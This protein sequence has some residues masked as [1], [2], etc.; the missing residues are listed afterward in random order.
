MSES[1]KEK[2][3][4]L[5]DLLAEPSV[6]EPASAVWAELSDEW[7]EFL[8]TLSD[9]AADAAKDLCKPAEGLGAVTGWTGR[10]WAK[11]V[12]AL[13]VWNRAKA[14]NPV[15][16]SWIGKL[17]GN[18]PETAEAGCKE[19]AALLYRK[20]LE[21]LKPDAASDRLSARQRVLLAVSL[22][23]LAKDVG[24]N[25]TDRAESRKSLHETPDAFVAE[26]IRRGLIEKGVA[27]GPA[28]VVSGWPAVLDDTNKFKDAFWAELK[29]LI[30][31]VGKAALP[32]FAAA[33]LV[34]ALTLGLLFLGVQNNNNRREF[35]KLQKGIKDIIP[36]AAKA[37]TAEDVIKAVAD[38]NA[39]VQ[40]DQAG[41]KDAARK[42]KSRIEELDTG[43]TSL[44]AEHAQLQAANNQNV[45]TIE[46][47]KKDLDAAT[48][49]AKKKG[50]DLA[51]L[52]D[53][54]KKA[55][56]EIA[57]QKSALADAAKT[58]A[59]RDAKIK[60][61]EGVLA[62]TKAD[63]DGTNAAL[64][65]KDRDLTAAKATIAK[66]D[67]EIK[68]LVGQLTNVNAALQASETKAASTAKELT[69]AKADLAKT[70]G[71]LA[72]AKKDLAASAD[73]VKS[74]T[75]ELAT[76][77]KDLAASAD[78]VKSLT[79]ELATA[80]TAGDKAAADLAASK[81]ELAST[82]DK[83]KSLMADVTKTGGDLSAA[84]TALAD[85]DKKLKAADAAAAKAAADLTAA[86]DAKTK[87]LA[88][89]EAVRKELE[90]V[91]KELKSL[92]DKAGMGG[93][94]ANP[95][96]VGGASVS[97]RGKG[98]PTAELAGCVVR[99][100]LDEDREALG[101][102]AAIKGLLVHEVKAGSKAAA[103]GLKADA[104]ITQI[105][106]DFAVGNQVVSQDVVVGDLAAFQAFADRVA[107]LKRND[108]KLKGYRFKTLTETVTVSE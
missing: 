21:A 70:A 61:V 81:K 104:V 26:L 7:A 25:L 15:G 71:E 108:N 75:G 35:E 4:D 73:Q 23:K 92:K 103:A 82:L 22:T 38:F 101:L 49:D 106:A 96:P 37:A 36:T 55:D 11:A 50:E 88:E 13:A 87:A 58:L 84:K 83:V 34:G 17:G 8:A 42:A 62:K 93:G 94:A 53:E 63:L 64:V 30:D 56:A 20:L 47:L 12:V 98:S 27:G 74:L 102:A 24:V 77:K 33:L 95:A 76:A 1:A 40:R 79:A 3:S 16:K 78:K 86:N 19:L 48:A 59:A 85:A 68:R 90:S 39:A 107:V 28:S 44:K 91:K 10:D 67:A 65:A 60:D 41:A 18:P 100:L 43:L 51:K 97:A 46:S 57:A 69:A 32:L 89:L 105:F 9:K 80:K 6:S 14:F 2:I 31:P 29:D 5:L 72:T 52:G 45:K 54:K 99:A 66:N